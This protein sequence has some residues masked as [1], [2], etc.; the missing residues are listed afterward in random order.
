V[1]KLLI[2]RG[3]TRLDER[4]LTRETVRI[5]RGA[6]NDL[7]LEDPGKGVSRN[8]AEIRFEGGRYTLV[9]LGSQ[10]GIWVSG[11]RVPSVVLEPGVSAAVGPYRLMLEAPVAAPVAAVAAVSDVDTAPIEPTQFS[12]PVPVDLDSLGSPPK[13]QEPAAAVAERRAASVAKEPPRK[14]RIKES[15][16]TKPQPSPLNTGWLAGVGALVLVAA[17]GFTAYKLMRK[18]APAAWDSS[19]AHALI[20]SGK[21]QEA[22][23]TQIAPALQ[24]NPSE[25]Q[26]LKLK[27]ECG[28]KLAP[29]APASTSSIPPPPSLDDRLNEAEPLLLTNVAAECQKGLDIING[30]V[31]EDATNQR[32]KDMAAKATACINPKPAAPAPAT[33]EKPAA[34]VPP[35]Q[36]GLDVIQG[37]TD[38]A[39]KARMAAARKKYEDAVALLASQKYSQAA[40]QFAELMNDVPSGYLDLQ[41][42]RD[43]ARAG[44]RAE[45][46]AA[47]E[48]AQAADGKDNYDAAIAGYRNAHQLDPNIQVEALIQRVNDR[49]LAAGRKR[50]TDGLLDF[51]LGNNPAALPALQEAVRL[52]PQTDACA[53]KARAALQQLSG[54]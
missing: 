27:D 41:Q 20:A 36:G 4:E 24:K 33:A 7:V 28:Q 31:A 48:A 29:A 11:S 25:P 1:A 32:A 38:K 51:S 52:L 10:N 22:L 9:D 21:C 23:D 19:V 34:P 46:K 45:G 39:Y 26:A 12:V 16:V 43:E 49:K 8:H 13:K 18:P 6:Q 40:A 14:E 42:R 30:V 44:M 17:V 37:E 5:G 53:V 3:D 35:S 50:C 2:F 47:L 15:T 54:K